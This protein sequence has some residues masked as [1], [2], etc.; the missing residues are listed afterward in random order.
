M[1]KRIITNAERVHEILYS[2]DSREELSVRI[3]TLEGLSRE[4]FPYVG[5]PCPDECKYCEECESE[6]NRGTDGFP[7]LCI[8]YNKYYET[9]NELGILE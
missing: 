8:A 5:D 7:L 9:L 4:L 1:S 6:S 3:A 2:C